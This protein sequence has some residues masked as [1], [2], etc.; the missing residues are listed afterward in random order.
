MDNRKDEK[1]RTLCATS[2]EGLKARGRCCDLVLF[3]GV[4][5]CVS[6][7][8]TYWVCGLADASRPWHT[9]EQGKTQLKGFIVFKFYRESFL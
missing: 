8:V 9:G 3:S 7:C 4:G 1:S 2:E 6:L 5:L